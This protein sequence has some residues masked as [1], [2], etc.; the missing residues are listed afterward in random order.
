M[1]FP[2][3]LAYFQSILFGG[4]YHAYVLSALPKEYSARML[5]VEQMMTHDFEVGIGA[6]ER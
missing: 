3:D 2:G 1:S 6:T 4:S 5:L